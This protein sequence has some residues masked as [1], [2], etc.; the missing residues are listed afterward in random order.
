[1]IEM[2]WA[3]MPDMKYLTMGS[4]KEFPD[5]NEEMQK[6]CKYTFH[7]TKELESFLFD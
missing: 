3:M 4:K 7:S 1:M 6:L 2:I 5:L